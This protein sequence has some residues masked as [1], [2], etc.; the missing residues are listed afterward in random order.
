MRARAAAVDGGALARSVC[1]RSLA[2]SAKSLRGATGERTE[3]ERERERLSRKAVKAALPSLFRFCNHR[4]R[5]RPAAAS[6]AAAVLLSGV[7][8]WWESEVMEREVS[9]SAMCA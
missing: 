4:P 7:I 6:T 3:G 9:E 5:P 2:R 8:S 1:A